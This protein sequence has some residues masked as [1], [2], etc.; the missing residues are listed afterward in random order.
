M[1]FLQV[2]EITLPYLADRVLLRFPVETGE[3]ILNR[4]VFLSD[5]LSDNAFLR[6]IGKGY[7]EFPSGRLEDMVRQAV[8]R[9]D[10]QILGSSD[11]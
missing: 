11:P 4:D 5:Q 2:I 8:E 10:R 9:G 3:D 7:L 1:V 6:G